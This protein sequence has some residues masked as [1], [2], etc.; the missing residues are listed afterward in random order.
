MSIPSEEMLE[1][2][3]E[4]AVPE[5]LSPSLIGRHGVT[6]AALAVALVLPLVV[7]NFLTFQLTLVLVYAIAI[8]GLGI[9]KSRTSEPPL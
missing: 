4:P 8:I 1:A 6:L 5:V 3:A 2:V 9:R 7:Q